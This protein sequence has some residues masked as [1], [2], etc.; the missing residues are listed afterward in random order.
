[1]SRYHLFT[2]PALVLAGVPAY[3]VTYHTVASA[4]EACF[5]GGHVFTA[6]PTLLTKEQLKAVERAGAGKLRGPM[7]E[8][9]RAEKGAQLAGWFLV[10]RV[11][12]KH[13]FITFA[14][15]L[16]PDG[17][18]LSLEIMDYQENYGGEVRNADWRFQFVGQGP[19]AKLQLGA[20]IRN[21]SGATLSCRHVTEGVKRLLA[22]YE[23]I[24]KH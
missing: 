17:T 10:D 23:L 4:Q 19:G 16:K 20:D 8:L 1:M 12:G 21:I 18:V 2:L 3:A 6:V 15:A 13:E 22:M 24:L 7:V 14:L 9:W 11:I 5:G